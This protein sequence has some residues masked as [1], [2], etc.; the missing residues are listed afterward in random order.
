MNKKKRDNL[1]WFL[2]LIS[3][4]SLGII[5]VLIISNILIRYFDVNLF[6]QGGLVLLITYLIYTLIWSKIFK[7][8]SGYSAW[9]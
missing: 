6:K 4:L 2:I 8:I 5:I 1:T 7:K 3:P 9:Y